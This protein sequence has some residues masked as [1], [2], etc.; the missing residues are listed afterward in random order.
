MQDQLATIDLAPLEELTA[1]QKEL[2]VLSGRLASMEERK[3]KVAPAVYAR[4]A[5]DYAAQRA[6]LEQRAEPLRAKARAEYARLHALRTQCEADHGAISLDREEVEFRFSLG[7]F[8]EPEYKR[9][10]KA[11]DAA[12]KEKDQA[13]AAAD[14]LRERFVEAFGS[15]EALEQAAAAPASAEPVQAETTQRMKTLPDAAAATDD[16]AA[17]PDDANATRVMR[18]LKGSE[19]APV[20]PDQTVVMRTARLVP[21]NP[22]AGKQNLALSLRPMRIGS[23]ASCDIRVAGARPEHAEIR[24]SMAGYSISDLGGGLRVNGVA[25][26]QHLLRQDDVIEVAA[27][28]FA[29]REG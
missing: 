24:V 6:A 10:L 17:A 16:A 15:A 28:R 27:A 7:E 13:R 23:E 5:S 4:V 11:V 1:I 8:E 25:V 29:F 19:A 18:T 14:T 2:D 22:E 12:L 20:R 26:E 3:G 21:Q 9:R